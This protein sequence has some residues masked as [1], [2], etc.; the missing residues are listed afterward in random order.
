MSGKLDH[1]KVIFW[2]V[3]MLKYLYFIC[4]SFIRNLILFI[5]WLY[6][7]FVIIICCC[8]ISK[9]S[10]KALLKKIVTRDKIACKL[11]Y[12]TKFL[13]KT[14]QNKLI[15]N[16]KITICFFVIHADV[17]Q[18]REL[19]HEYSHDKR[20]NPL[21]VVCPYDLYGLARMIENMNKTY[22]YF[23]K[24]KYNVVKTYNPISKKFLNVYKEYAPS[25]VFFTNPHKLTNSLYYIDFWRGKAIA[26]YVPYGIMQ[27]KL[28]ES[29][30]NQ[31][32]H[33][34]V[35][36]IFCESLLTYNLSK[37]YADNRGENVVIT[38]YPKCDVFLDTSYIPK[39]V[40][41][42]KDKRIKRIIWAPHHTIEENKEILGYSCFLIISDLMINI[43]KKYREKIQIAF[44]PHPILKEKLYNHTEWGKEKTDIYYE[45]WNSQ[46]NT[47]LEVSEY[48][49]LFLTSD[50][51]ILDSISFMA[52]YMFTEKPL[53]FTIRDNTIKNKFNEFGEKVFENI[54][55]AFNDNDLT[56]FI[57]DVIE[58][59]D[60]KVDDRKIFMSEYLLPP[61]NKTATENII[62]SINSE[63]IESKGN[64]MGILQWLK[65][66]KEQK[67]A[68][69]DWKTRTQ[70]NYSQNCPERYRAQ[71][72]FLNTYFVSKLS[73]TDEI[74]DV[75]CANGWVSIE[76]SKYV[77]QIEAYD[78]SDILLS[79]AKQTAIEEN[80]S[81]ISFKKF[82]ILKDKINKVY[83][84]IIV[85][86]LFNYIISDDDMKKVLLDLYDLLNNNGLLVIKEALS[87]D[88]ERVVTSTKSYASTLRSVKR[89][90]EIYRS[91]G[92][93]VVSSVIAIDKASSTEM[94]FATFKK[95][96][97]SE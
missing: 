22:D 9:L 25:I 27:A 91:A 76:L 13:Y 7:N 60:P 89:N 85:M 86:G 84:H 8:L 88:K 56:M 61:N 33:N 97:N 87:H 55:K 24:L 59:I 45:F 73:K 92:F 94:L 18:Y 72:D 26:Y 28:E 46:V 64:N 43:A 57:D 75:A 38:G 63:I 34:K 90:F 79:Q 66:N 96:T 39:D 70:F 62:E 4:I 12:K 54:Y 71:L 2:V 65:S 49:D 11:D 93:E 47:Q 83:D 37:Q 41:K 6:G 48:V 31:P 42:L 44:K 80:I 53:I 67:I 29:Q 58:E 30:F 40:W 69:N 10:R 82:D 74:A 78:I 16:E 20:F 23:N 21:I 14:I 17:W 5:K 32:F 51:M 81:N 77:K 36:K 35:T 1:L 3:K 95:V 50:A 19:Y 68:K 15:N 52:E